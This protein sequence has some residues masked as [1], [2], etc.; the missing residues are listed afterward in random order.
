MFSLKKKKNKYILSSLFFLVFASFLFFGN[1]ENAMAVEPSITSCAKHPIDCSLAVTL[2]GES[3]ILSAT[4]A[5]FGYIVDAK[6][7]KAI[8]GHKKIYDAWKIVRDMLNFVFILVLIFIAFSTIFQVEKYNYKKLLLTLVVMA[9]LVNF[10]FPITRFIIDVSNVLMY[11]IMTELFPATTGIGIFEQ[12]AKD[13]GISNI[14][15][16]TNLVG[17]S[18]APLLL[19]SVIFV[20]IFTITLF[21]LTIL[22]VIR[23]IALAVLIIFSSLGFIGMILPDT[24]KYAK[25]FWDTLF[26]YALFGPIMLF[27]LYVATEIMN[28]SSEKEAVFKGLAEFTTEGNS[29]GFIASMAFFFIPIIVLWLGMGMAQKMG[30]AGADM[31]T[32]KAKGAVKKVGMGTAG[33]LG[34]N[35]VR[36]MGKTFAAARQERESAKDKASFGGSLGRGLNAAQDRTLGVVPVL[37]RGANQR[38]T[39]ASQDRRRQSVNDTAT[40]LTDSGLNFGAVVTHLNASFDGTTGDMNQTISQDQAAHARAFSRQSGDQQ[41]GNLRTELL[42]SGLA[43]MANIRTAALAQARGD[44]VT[45]LDRIDAEP[46]ATRAAFIDANQDLLNSVNGFMNQ[47]ADHVVREHI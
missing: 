11:T 3:Y 43:H 20:F 10:S 30:V 17:E 44:V 19:M 38:A 46:A 13:S 5:L 27:M 41:R 1:F 29:V 16:N 14:L 33:M 35:A 15:S 22:L 9:L 45:A 31:I 47:E 12:I 7:M 40:R 37:G 8:F 25:D 42:T 2:K 34:L 24:S 36:R 18:Q 6:E 28:V 26:K 23:A 32:N 4:V 39:R 21:A